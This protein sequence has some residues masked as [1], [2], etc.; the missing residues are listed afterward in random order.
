MII[1]IWN[2]RGVGNQKSQQLASFYK[3]TKK[4]D[5][6]FLLEPMVG[7]NAPKFCSL[8]GFTTIVANFSNKIWACSTAQFSINILKDEEQFL[9]CEIKDLG[10]NTSFF[11]TIVYAKCN[12]RERR[13]LWTGL[14]NCAVPPN[15]PWCVGGDFNIFSSI[16]ERVGG[17]GTPP[18]LNAMSEFN[19]CI[20]QNGL[21]DLGFSG[22]PF[23]WER[24]DGMKQRLDRILFNSAWESAFQRTVTVHGVHTKI[25]HHRPIFIE[26][27]QSG[28]IRKGSFKFQNIW[29]LHASFLNEVEKNWGMPARCTGLKKFKEKL[30]RLKQFLIFWN[31]TLLETFF[32]I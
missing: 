13:E 24:P 6:L 21:K 20:M 25:S 30:Y 23:T 9:H 3:K 14:S 32:K 10:T 26:T 19:T 8:L 2:I 28:E 22:P 4:L 11:A 5:F 31:S 27:F 12:M 17:G 15:T 29:T 16:A 18:D 7:L 1:Q